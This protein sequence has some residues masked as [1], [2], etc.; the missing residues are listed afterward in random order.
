LLLV[1]LRPVAAQT[2]SPKIDRSLRESIR[3]GSP[4]QKVI[5]S[6]R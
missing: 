5:I 1:G 4:T 2:S 3:G 6:D